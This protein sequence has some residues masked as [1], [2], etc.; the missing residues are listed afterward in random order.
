LIIFRCAF[1]VHNQIEI[2]E[3]ERRWPTE[4]FREIGEKGRGNFLSTGL[5]DRITGEFLFRCGLTW[6]TFWR[7]KSS[8]ARLHL[9]HSG[10]SNFMKFHENNLPT[11][12]IFFSEFFFT[13]L[14]YIGGR[15]NELFRKKID[16]SLDWEIYYRTRG[17][18]FE[19]LSCF[20]GPCS[21]FISVW[22]YWLDLSCPSVHHS[23][24][25]YKF[26]K[27]FWK[28]SI[29]N[30]KKKNG[31]DHRVRTSARPRAS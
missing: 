4:N 12:K 25:T 21:E 10:W 29:I 20:I 17:G 26:W 13:Q 31:S 7:S 30:N 28:I 9:S 19:F 3:K 2:W 15:V 6:T 18:E 22:N 14:K 27:F 16:R 1:F 11:P 5:I 24:Y 8:I 23:N